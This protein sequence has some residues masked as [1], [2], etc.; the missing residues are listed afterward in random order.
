MTG[1]L[2]AKVVGSSIILTAA[3]CS[4][5]G[6][7]SGHAADTI[8]RNAKIYTVDDSR[9][10][11][12]AL[13]VGD[14]RITFVGDESDIEKYIEDDTRIIDAEGQL[15]L[16]GF[17]DSH[18]HV[19]YGTDTQGVNLS[20]AEDLTAFRKMLSAYADANPDLEWIIADG[21]YYG[22]FPDDIPSW[23]DLEGIGNGRPMMLTS[24]DAH[25]SLFNKAALDLMGIDA[26][27]KD[28]PFGELV[29]DRDGN[30]TGVVKATLYAPN[31]GYDFLSQYLPPPDPEEDYRRLIGNL[32]KATRFG[33]TTIV[34]PQNYLDDLYLYERA[35]DEGKINSYLSLAMLYATD[36]SK[37]SI[38]DF[39]QARYRF[40]DKP[41][42]KIDAVKLYIDDV[43]EAG[44][45]AMLQP[46]ANRP[47]NLGRTFFTQK[48]L[49]RIVQDL[50]LE[51]FRVFI[52]AIGDRGIRMAL[53][54]FEAAREKN[55]LG[56]TRHQL[57]HV[58]MVHPD[59]IPRFAEL[60]V[61]ACMQPRHAA[62]SFN[63]PWARAVGAFRFRGAWPFRS[64]EQAGAVIAFSSDYDVAEMD[65]LIGIYSAITR[66]DEN[67][68]PEGGWVPDERVSLETAIRAYTLNG[69]YAVALDRERGSIEIG[70]FADL[71]LLSRNLFEIAPKDILETQVAMTMFEGEIVFEQPTP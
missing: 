26:G 53:N 17:V 63:T 68:L 19:A 6:I 25:T 36:S 64:L 31:A 24:A 21:W 54:A 61:V 18:N 52:H 9:P 11:A 51:G 3:S 69:A 8:V 15:L 42:I 10:W 13:A 20:E 5:L 1:Y 4:V 56:N 2:T 37:A 58:E 59:D 48:K 16:P 43:I 14:G 41:H 30:P 62:L 46:Y 60:G 71:V 44:T 7:D 70:K 22:I 55:R 67:G 23:Q 28:V 34:E 39:A 40:R 35:E 65:P 32:E 38:R 49:N 57:V 33:I 47:G 45:A 50:E 27:T 12:E 29:K 66:Q